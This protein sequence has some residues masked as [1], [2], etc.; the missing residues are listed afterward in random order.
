MGMKKISAKDQKS[1]VRLLREW[2]YADKLTWESL[3]ERI[4]S[5]LC[6][7][8]EDVWSRQSLSANESIATAFKIAKTKRASNRSVRHARDEPGQAAT[9]SRLESELAEITLKYEQLLL[10]HTRLAYN[11]SLLEGG[12]KLLDDP[13][14]DNTTSQRG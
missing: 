10:R 8:C 1:V 14:P 9:I 2:A 6:C 13:L 4:A 12:T 11:A 3:R 7:A 5:S